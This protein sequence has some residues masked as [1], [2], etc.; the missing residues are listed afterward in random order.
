MPTEE[1]QSRR[2][3]WKG[4][5]CYRCT[6]YTYNA[7]TGTRHWRDCLRRLSWAKSGMIG[8]MNIIWKFFRRFVIRLAVHMLVGTVLHVSKYWYFP[9]NR[10][11][12]SESVF[13]AS[14][15]FQKVQWQLSAHWLAVMP[16]GYQSETFAGALPTATTTSSN[17]K[18]PVPEFD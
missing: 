3:C 10:A 9:F 11:R 7:H 14:E 17:G 8:H 1:H 4:V 6:L 16:E 18:I 2:K 13:N 5:Q 12:D 15:N